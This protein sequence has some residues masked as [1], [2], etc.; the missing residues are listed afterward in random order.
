L[1]FEFILNPAG[2]GFKTFG[3][4]LAN[5][6]GEGYLRDNGLKIA[7]VKQRG[8]QV[9]WTLA[10]G[11]GEGE[12][13]VFQKGSLSAAGR[14]KD[15]EVAAMLVLKKGPDVTVIVGCQAGLAQHVDGNLVRGL[16]GEGEFDENLV[17]FEGIGSLCVQTLN[18]EGAVLEIDCA[19]VAGEKR[20][21]FR[22]RPLGHGVDVLGLQLIPDFDDEC[23]AENEQFA[24]DCGDNRMIVEKYR[25][26]LVGTATAATSRMPFA[27]LFP[28]G[29]LVPRGSGSIQFPD[30]T[31]MVRRTE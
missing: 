12:R 22:P 27:S 26:A 29:T 10:P 31:L 16:G 8:G 2:G 25:A 3:Q 17:E 30:S 21:E 20:L 23:G 6:V 24:A 28:S 1:V 9:K 11:S 15:C 7:Q 13:N 5:G 19:A 4:R 14:A 18:V